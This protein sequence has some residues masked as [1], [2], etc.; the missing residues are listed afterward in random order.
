MVLIGIKEKKDI[1]EIE[2]YFSPYPHIELEIPE[3][4]NWKND[5]WLYKKISEF[6]IGVSP[7][8]D[9]EFNRAKSA[10]KAKQYLSCGI[11]AI[12]SDIGENSTFV[13]HQVN[14]LICNE[15]N[16][17]K[18]GIESIL[19]LTDVDYKKMS[20]KAFEDRSSFSMPSYCENLIEFVNLFHE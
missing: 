19:N 2:K 18:T 1:P 4:I 7:M 6:D 17:Y 5:N 15:I 12:A 16:D 8:L 20:T 3:N 13:K 14:G 9:F 11:P 10:F